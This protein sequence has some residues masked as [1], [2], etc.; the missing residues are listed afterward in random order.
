ML[1]GDGHLVRT[2]F[3]RVWGAGD[4]SAASELFDPGFRHHD[5]VTGAETGLGG[6]LASIRSIRDLF[7]ELEFVIHDLAVADGRVASRWEAVGAHRG[8][9]REVR[10]DGMSFDHIREGRIVENWTVWDRQGL[11]TQ[12]PEEFG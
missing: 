5:L 7:S 2:F 8:S 1:G 11:A 12:L 9:G 10:V 3:D 4:E 6:F